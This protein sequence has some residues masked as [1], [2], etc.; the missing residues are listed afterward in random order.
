[1]KGKDKDVRDAVAASNSLEIMPLEK[2]LQAYS[3]T[4][5]RTV[6]VY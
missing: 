5:S 2:K 4:V 6:V 3:D 1:M